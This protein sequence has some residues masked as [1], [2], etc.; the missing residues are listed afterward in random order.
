MEYISLTVDVCGVFA[1][2]TK[3]RETP[4]AIIDYRRVDENIKACYPTVSTL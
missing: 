3:R 4:T 2:R 1:E